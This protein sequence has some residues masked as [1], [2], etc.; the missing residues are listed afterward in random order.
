[1]TKNELTISIATPSEIDIIREIAWKTFPLTYRDIISASQI[2]YMMEWM[3]S[4]ANL[5]KQMT[6]DHH[7]YLLAH[8]DNKTIGYVSVEPQEPDLWHLHK[9]YVLPSYQGHH[10][11]SFLFRRAVE[12]IRE[13]AQL[14][15]K[16][17]LNVNRNNQ[18]VDF[19]YHMGMRK[20]R[21]GDFDIGNGFFMND[22]IMVLEIMDDNRK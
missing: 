21:Q 19:Y 15:C 2:E 3:Y 18:A 20:D 11:G 8:L 6:E 16:M 12:Y 22:Y 5:L 7:T 1:M 14:P 4:E 13:R 10:C 9:L 17:E